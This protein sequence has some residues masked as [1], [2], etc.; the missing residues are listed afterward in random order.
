MKLS[1]Q[2]KEKI[3]GPNQT[4]RVPR[5]TKQSGSVW[6]AHQKQSCKLVSLHLSF[7]FPP[8]LWDTRPPWDRSKNHNK[9]YFCGQTRPQDYYSTRRYKWCTGCPHLPA[10]AAGG[11]RMLFSMERPGPREKERERKREALLRGPRDTA[12]VRPNSLCSPYPG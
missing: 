2:Q 12:S 10:V 9:R 6:P 4:R 1:S 11:R 8:A 5:S 7:S 3:F